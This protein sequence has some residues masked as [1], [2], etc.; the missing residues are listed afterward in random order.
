MDILIPPPEASTET[1][2]TYAVKTDD[3]IETHYKML[4]EQDLRLQ[5]EEDA[6]YISMLS[7][8]EE[9]DMET[10]TDEATYS[11]FV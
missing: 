10:D 3:S 4:T 5:R 9:S 6:I 2:A 8:E 7:E 11:Y 1:P